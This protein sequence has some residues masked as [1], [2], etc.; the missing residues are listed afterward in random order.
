MRPLRGVFRAEAMAARRKRNARF[1][2]QRESEK[3]LQNQGLVA[4]RSRKFREKIVQNE[5]SH[6]GSEGPTPQLIV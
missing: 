2:G 6:C 1:F 4:I 5:T 3:G